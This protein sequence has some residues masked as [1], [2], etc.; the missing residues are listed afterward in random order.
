MNA[1]QSTLLVIGV[2]IVSFSAPLIRLTEAPALTVAMYRNLFAAAVLVPLA[3]VFSRQQLRRLS[4]RDVLALVGSGLLLAIHFSTWIPSVRL[5]TVAASTV[6]VSTSPLWTALFA[7][8]FLRDR[9]PRA[10]LA[11]TGIAFAGAIL[12]SGF[13]FTLSIRAF[14]GDMLALAGAA[15]V[16]GHRV[17]GLGPRKRLEVLPF[18][19]VIYGACA[20]ALAIF[21][22]LTGNR[23]TGFSAE[24]WAYMI[25]MALGPQLVGHT[26]FN[27]LLRD[28]DPT[29]LAVA[30]MGEAVGATLLAL[31]FFGEVPSIGAIAGGL[32][33]LLGIFVAVR[34]QSRRLLE[35]PVE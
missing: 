26:L 20:V 35:T 4:R 15:A 25:L 10:V 16:A 24:S 6:L 9:L 29:V 7:R 33:L 5:T 30:I 21:V 12:I 3:F 1:R 27:F 8:V 23:V 28:V 2:A 13:D 22:P 34:A 14:G 18:V 31:A 11:G 32:L 17:M 19:A